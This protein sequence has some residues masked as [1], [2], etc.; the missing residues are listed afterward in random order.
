[1]S[2]WSGDQLG[3]IHSCISGYQNTL[4][5]QIIY[6]VAAVPFDKRKG[7]SSNGFAGG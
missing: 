7:F 1:M 5:H 2:S 3:R 4:H 6:I